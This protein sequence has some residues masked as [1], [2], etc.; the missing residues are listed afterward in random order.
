MSRRVLEYI[1]L[2]ALP[3]LLS[4]EVKM[5][6]EVLKPE[7]MEALLYDYHSVQAMSGEYAPGSYK[8][9]LYYDYVFKK[10]NVTKEQFDSSLVWYNRYPKHMLKIYKKLEARFEAEVE[11]L[12]SA[13]GALD[14]GVSLSIAYLATDTAEL[15]TSSTTKVLLSSPLCS[16]LAFAFETPADSAF[17]PGDS[18]SF[19][20]NATFATGGVQGVQQ[21]AYAAIQ[22]AYEDGAVYSKGLPV[23]NNGNAV[24]ALERYQGSRLKSMNGYV[25][26]FDNDT[27]ALSRLI[28]SDISVERIHPLL[29]DSIDGKRKGGMNNRS[30]SK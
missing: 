7:K 26:Y 16:R 30:K 29:A 23:K 6:E 14:E 18:L 10:H 22:L 15:W 21:E 25:Y 4:C 12:G 24:V 13:K 17:L 19:S 28:L 1:L 27:L 11:A 2:L 9:K 20:F 3:L 5:P 8:E